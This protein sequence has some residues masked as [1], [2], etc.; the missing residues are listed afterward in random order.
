MEITSLSQLDSNKTYTYA[1]YL[2]WKFKE[3]V[4]LFKGKV[5]A[6]SLAPR[7]DHQQISGRLHKILFSY[8][9]NRDYQLFSTPFDVRLPNA[10]GKEVVTVVQPDL[11]VVI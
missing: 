2:L 1:D 3:R 9:E 7:T 6:M 10:Q 5:F 11:R 4:E 8:F